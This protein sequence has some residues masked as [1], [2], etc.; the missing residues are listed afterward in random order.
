[1]A[2]KISKRPRSTQSRTLPPDAASLVEMI[3]ALTRHILREIVQLKDSRGHDARARHHFLMLTTQRAEAYTALVLLAQQGK[4]S[5][6]SELLA[7]LGLVYSQPT[8][9]V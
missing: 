9:E 1:M 2:K 6:L 4:T 3:R 7:E 8:A 5:G